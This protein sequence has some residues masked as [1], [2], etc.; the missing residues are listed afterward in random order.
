MCSMPKTLLFVYG[1]LKNGQR[2]HSVLGNGSDN[3]GTYLTEEDNFDMVTYASSFPIIYWKENAFKI[4]GEVYEVT[5]QT[6]DT[7]NAI[8]SNAG[9]IPFIVEVYEEDYPEGEPL[10]VITYIYPNAQGI[11]LAMENYTV[12]D[13]DGIKEWKK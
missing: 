7:V 2:L 13:V 8:E 5:P 3:L 9:Y 10:K 11:G 4:R 12:S 1:T 6:M